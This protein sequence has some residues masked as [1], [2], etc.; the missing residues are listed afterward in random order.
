M[1]ICDEGGGGG[2]MLLFPK[3]SGLEWPLEPSKNQF[4]TRFS[5]K[6]RIGPTCNITKNDRLNPQKKMAKTDFFYFHPI[7][8]HPVFKRSNSWKNTK[9]SQGIAIYS[10]VTRRTD[11]KQKHKRMA[12][13]RRIK[14]PKPISF[15]LTCE[16]EIQG[17]TDFLTQ[18]FV[19]IDICASDRPKNTTRS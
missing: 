8:L 15:I 3:K 1:M 9:S 6:P 13:G 5:Q 4:Q 17:N 11:L 10:K 19:F 7:F 16:D 18:M 12:F 2:L 14:L